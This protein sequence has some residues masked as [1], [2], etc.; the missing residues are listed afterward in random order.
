MLRM[1]FITQSAKNLLSN[2][3]EDARVSDANSCDRNETIVI[4]SHTFNLNKEM[5]YLTSDI[6]KVLPN[7]GKL[8]SILLLGISHFTQ[9]DLR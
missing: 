8:S 5:S 6:R 3:N 1:S 4:S 2:M 7:E 9:D